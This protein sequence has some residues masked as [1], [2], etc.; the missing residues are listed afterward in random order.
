MQGFRSDLRNGIQ[1]GKDFWESMRDAALNALN[2][3]ADK[4]FEVATNQLIAAVLGGG[5]FGGPSP[6]MA[7][8]GSAFS[9]FARGTNNAPGGMA[10][11]GERGP[12]LVNLPRGSQVTPANETA[13]TLGKWSS[14][15]F[16][17]TINI[18]A[19]GAGPGVE[20]KIKAEV[21]SALANYAGGEYDRFRANHERALKRDYRYRN[22]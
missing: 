1:Q 8:S 11:V 20:Q 6:A 18:D 19:R 13:N 4:L 10:L 16:S 22:G 7:F 15:G 9:L 14:G 2:S 17:P 3:I 21:D 12:E 5:T